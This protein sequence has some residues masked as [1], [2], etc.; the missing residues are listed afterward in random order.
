MGV[1][2]A[3]LIRLLA[4]LLCG[5]WWTAE[6]A[7]SS[8]REKP[9]VS[10]SDIIDSNIIDSDKGTSRLWDVSHLIA[11]FGIAVGFTNL[12]QVRTGTRFMGATGL[13]L[14]LAGI[15]LR[16][17]AIATL[18]DYFT[19]KVRILSEHRLVRSG[20]YR[21]ARHPAY[22]GALV[23]YLGLGLSFANWISFVLIFF[24]VLLAALRRI[25]VEEEA[26]RQAFGKEYVEYSEKTKRLLPGIY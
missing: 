22:S 20:V 24:P 14:M 23:A 4:S 6:F 9:R 1:G 13:A 8:L 7:R 2:T 26:L 18:G 19:G 11:V 10:D 21:Y 5:C 17:S 25:R 16:S 15:I 3:M 12:G